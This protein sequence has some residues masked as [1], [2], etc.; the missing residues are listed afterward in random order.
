MLNWIKI[1]EGLPKKSGKY[2]LIKRTFFKGWGHPFVL[3][4]F[5]QKRKQFYQTRSD[6]VNHKNI[7]HWAEIYDPEDIG[8]SEKELENRERLI[9]MGIL[10]TLEYR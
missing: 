2:Y 9:N 4:S 1:E 3:C 5:S 7:T 8:I 10:E 6:E